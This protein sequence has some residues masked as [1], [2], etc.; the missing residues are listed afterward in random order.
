[1]IPSTSDRLA[2][3]KQHSIDGGTL[4]ALAVAAGF[5]FMCGRVLWGML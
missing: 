4:L 1:M 2:F 3:A 5:A